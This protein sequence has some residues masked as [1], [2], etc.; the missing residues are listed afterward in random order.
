[1]RGSEGG[2]ECCEGTY[3]LDASGLFHLRHGSLLRG[4]ILTTRQVVDEVKDYRS[5]ALLDVLGVEV[6]EVPDKEVRKI[7]AKHPALSLAD[8]SLVVLAKTLPCVTVVTD[9]MQLAVVLRRYGV[10]V[11]KVF[12]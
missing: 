2:S 3:V 10:R 8:A 1:M 5:L 12:Y 7:L 9:D 4:R 11:M 6:V